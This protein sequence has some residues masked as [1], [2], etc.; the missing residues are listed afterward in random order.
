MQTIRVPQGTVMTKHENDRHFMYNHHFE[1][2]VEISKPDFY[3]A[4]S[5]GRVS[6]FSI[7]GATAVYHFNDIVVH[8]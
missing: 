5:A 6:K 3:T 1:K 4:F 2:W 8:E 7:D